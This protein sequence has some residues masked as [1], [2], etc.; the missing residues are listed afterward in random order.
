M[1]QA[2]P[3][4]LLANSSAGSGDERVL[5]QVVG[6]L[7][8][9]AEVD[10]VRPGAEDDLREV[11]RGVAGRDVVVM[12][13]DGSVHAC[14]ATLDDLGLLGEV[15]VGIVPAGTGN[16]LARALGLPLDPAS[17][18]EVAVDGAV[19]E[20]DLL[21]Q[22]SGGVVVNA[23]HAGVAARA[24]A[25]AEEVKGLFGT[26]GYL[27]GAARAG[28]GARGWRLR[29]EVDGTVVADGTERAL[30]VSVVVGRTIGGG[31]EVAPGGE[32]DDR[33]ADVVVSSA[34]GLWQRVAFAR[35]LRRGR[36]TDRDDVTALV[37]RDVVVEAV[38]ADDAFRLNTDGDVG[39][40][41]VRRA[42][43]LLEPAAWRCRV[44]VT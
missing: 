32:P 28:L 11:L 30:M 8:A 35:D 29:V 23:V 24:T 19:L 4:L 36:H 27:L 41:A 44:P 16:D 6:V 21:R 9:R 18:A 26:L 42:R 2:H 22:Q 7:S 12:G 40:E 33:R 5:A 31:T 37:G 38:G 39:E 15:T 14:V 34:T 20:V 25:Y 1:P 10:V 13:G 3:V 17:A 43:W